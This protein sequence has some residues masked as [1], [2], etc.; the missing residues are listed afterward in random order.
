M[1]CCGARLGIRRGC[2]SLPAV[3]ADLIADHAA[4][5]GTADSTE[6]VAVRDF[7]DT[8]VRFTQVVG[9]LT[10]K[11]LRNA[12]RYERLLQRQSEPQAEGHRAELERIALVSFLKRFLD[13]FHGRAGARAEGLLPQ[14]SSDELDRLVEIAMA[15]VT[16]EGKGR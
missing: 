7:S 3:S 15:V 14:S 5:C 16:E 12:F 13:A 9:S 10:A 11:A 1:H 6:R 8:D 2:H 4:N